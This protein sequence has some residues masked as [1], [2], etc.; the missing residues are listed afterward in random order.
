MNQCYMR[1]IIR[2]Y[3]CIGHVLARHHLTPAGDGRNSH[4]PVT[5]YSKVKVQ[6]Q[7]NKITLT[8]AA[9]AR[10]C[11]HTVKQ[12]ICVRNLRV[13][14]LCVHHITHSRTASQ[15]VCHAV[16]DFTYP[17][18]GALHAGDLGGLELTFLI[19]DQ[20]KWS[21]STALFGQQLENKFES[22]WYLCLQC[23]Q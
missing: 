12:E 21:I 4:S 9:K 14:V 22:Y 13:S 15:F 18:Q 7:C 20:G 16:R 2:G 8:V 10:Q 19:Q 23:M 5:G 1:L 17:C 11:F 3:L 6:Q